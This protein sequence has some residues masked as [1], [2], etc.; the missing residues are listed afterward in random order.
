MTKD[1]IRSFQN[2][3]DKL[4]RSCP[5]KLTATREE[6]IK[7][8]AIHLLQGE[9]PMILRR[10]IVGQR[11]DSPSNERESQAIAAYH[12]ARARVREMI[13]QSSEQEIEELFDRAGC[14]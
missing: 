2:R 8:L 11:F 5:V 1:T 3:L 7:R 9:D 4:E 14:R 10:M 6:L 12:S 13:A